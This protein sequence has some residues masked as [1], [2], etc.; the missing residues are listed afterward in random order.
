MQGKSR[1]PGGGPVHLTVPQG[2]GEVALL[3]GWLGVCQPQHQG[4]STSALVLN[5]SRLLQTA[6]LCVPEEADGGV[7]L[8]R[9]LELPLYQ[10]IVRKA[11][12]V[13]WG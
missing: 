10:V 3:L 13:V 2:Q 1:R 6:R 4:P 5:L 8:G 11:V 12:G 9:N 7:V